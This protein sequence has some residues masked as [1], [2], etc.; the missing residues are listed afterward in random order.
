MARNCDCVCVGGSLTVTVIR[1]W[2]VCAWVH[3]M[4]RV[5]C[6]CICQQGCV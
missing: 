6:E 2:I 4:G 1:V 5:G 3:V